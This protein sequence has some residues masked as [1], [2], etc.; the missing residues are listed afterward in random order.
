M[1]PPP[2]LWHPPGA[3]IPEKVIQH[4]RKAQGGSGGQALSP[5][6]LDIHNLLKGLGFQQSQNILMIPSPGHKR[7]EIFENG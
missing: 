5:P 3:I 6:I 1:P 4:Y 2:P 7:V